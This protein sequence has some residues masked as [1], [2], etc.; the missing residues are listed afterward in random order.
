MIYSRPS[1]PSP[2]LDCTD[3]TLESSFICN[4]D[5]VSKFRWSDNRSDRQKWKTVQNLVNCGGHDGNG[6]L[7][8]LVKTDN[9]NVNRI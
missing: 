4:L 2:R 5:M 6:V 9:T 1:A 3:A 8:S 7:L